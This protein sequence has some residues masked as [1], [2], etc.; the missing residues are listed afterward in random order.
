MSTS[1]IQLV[2][3]LIERCLQMYMSQ[4]EV[5][6]TLHGQA[7]IE[8]GFTG[9]VWQ[10]SIWN[11]SSAIALPPMMCRCAAPGQHAANAWQ[12]LPRLDPGQ[13]QYVMMCV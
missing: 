13:N 1:D 8:P 2:Q 3:N 10:A 7:K 5:V 9:L 12:A 11:I 4:K 6:N